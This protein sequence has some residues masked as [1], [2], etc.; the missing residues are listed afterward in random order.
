MT[1][2]LKNGNKPFDLRNCKLCGA[3]KRKTGEPCRAKAMKNGR[4]RIHGGTSTSAKTEEGKERRNKANYKEG[5]YRKEMLEF[6]KRVTEVI[7]KSKNMRLKLFTSL[8]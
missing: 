4:C 6:E 7:R 8:L 5:R 1:Y 3:K 2:L